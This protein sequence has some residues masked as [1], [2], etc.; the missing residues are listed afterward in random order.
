M[1][2]YSKEELQHVTATPGRI[3]SELDRLQVDMENSVLKIG[4]IV[5]AIRKIH[6]EDDLEGFRGIWPMSF[7]NSCELAATGKID[8]RLALLKGQHY[9]KMESY[10]ID[11][12]YRAISEGV[13]LIDVGHDEDGNLTGSASSD[14]NEFLDEMTQAQRAQVM[15]P[16]GFRTASEQ[17]DWY[18]EQLKKRKAKEEKQSSPYVIERGR[19][20]VNAPGMSFGKKDL[21]KILA[22]LIG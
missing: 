14:V 16:K 13:L 7:L 21:V 18:E 1:H 6:P 3:A 20:T 10:P 19:L 22:E 17:L 5:R 9:R 11:E 15:G 4:Q 12:Q 8:P 2:T